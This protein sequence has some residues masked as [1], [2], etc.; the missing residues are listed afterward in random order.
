MM[1]I[2]FV[3]DSRVKSGGCIFGVRSDGEITGHKQPA[4][5]L[6]PHMQGELKSSLVFITC[7]NQTTRGRYCIGFCSENT[8]FNKMKDGP[9]VNVSLIVVKGMIYDEGAIKVVFHR[10]KGKGCCNNLHEELLRYKCNAN[11]FVQQFFNPEPEAVDVDEID[12]AYVNQIL[13]RRLDDWSQEPSVFKHID[14]HYYYKA[15]TQPDSFCQ[16][17]PFPDSKRYNYLDPPKDRTKLP[18]TKLKKPY[19]GDET[20]K[21]IGSPKLRVHENSTTK[22][23]YALQQDNTTA[24]GK[25]NKYTDT[26]DDAGEDKKEKTVRPL[27]QAM[28]SSTSDSKVLLNPISKE[29][30]KLVE[31]KCRDE[32]G[33]LTPEVFTQE[34][35]KYTDTF[36]AKSIEVEKIALDKVSPNKVSIHI[37]HI[38]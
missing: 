29:D 5:Y 23:V 20:A 26:S 22:I 8:K 2:P 11:A 15:K 4:G 17:D 36:D 7:P 6:I 30:R 34:I 12:I 35:Q 3:E 27:F 28:P 24:F 16:H 25:F 33:W 1:K 32:G 19:K 37:Y 9:L 18:N 31:K 38:I 21:Y 14:G 10:W 13:G